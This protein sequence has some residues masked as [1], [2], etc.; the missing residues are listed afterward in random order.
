MVVS[1]VRLIRSKG[2]LEPFCV[3]AITR[4]R[5]GIAVRADRVRLRAFVIVAFRKVLVVLRKIM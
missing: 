5:E 4:E 3:L 2:G 1:Q